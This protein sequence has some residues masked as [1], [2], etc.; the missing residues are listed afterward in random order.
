M[1]A[2]LLRL[3]IICPCFFGAFSY[4][5]TSAIWVYAIYSIYLYHKITPKEDVMW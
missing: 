3:S 1:V 5:K 4:Q 2:F